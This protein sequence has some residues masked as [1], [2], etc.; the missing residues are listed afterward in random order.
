MKLRLI[1]VAIVLL[2]TT[3][4]PA[5]AQDMPTI[6]IATWAGVD[7]A[8]EFQTIIDEINA[9]STEYQIVHQPTP[10]DYYV[11]VETQLAAPGTGADR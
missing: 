4:G 2:M 7:E 3:L 10:A 11:V 9:N 8:A 6:T 1:A 5:I